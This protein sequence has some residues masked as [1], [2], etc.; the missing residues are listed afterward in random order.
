MRCV[1]IDDE[2]SN[3]ENL[4]NILSHYFQQ[5]LVVGVAQSADSGIKLIQQ[6]HP[7][8]VFLD[9]KMPGNNGFQM[10]ERISEINFEIIFVTAFE[11]FALKAIKFSALDYLVKPIDLAELEESLGRAEK[12]IKDKQTNHRLMHFIQNNQSPAL[13]SRKMPLST[14][15]KL[16]FVTVSDIIRCEGQV[17]YTRFHLV[18]QAPIL[19]SKTLKEYEELLT[20]YQFARVHQSHLINMAHVAAFVK[21]DGGYLSMNDGSSVSVARNRKEK[22][23]QLL[24]NM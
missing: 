2:K 18:N 14:V 22:V 9:I 13:Q 21:S 7:D 12:R 23:L 17:N 24:N 10:L 6:E 19:V 1:I 8:L 3:I 16:I 11:E 15:D 4:S 20:P 5:V